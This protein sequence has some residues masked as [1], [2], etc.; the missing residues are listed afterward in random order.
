MAD[1]KSVCSTT[2]SSGPKSRKCRN[3][4]CAN[5]RPYLNRFDHHDLCVHCLGENHDCEHCVDC[6][7]LSARNLQFRKDA[8]QYKREFGKWPPKI[9]SRAM[10]KRKE[11]S[12]REPSATVTASSGDGAK[13][14]SLAEYKARSFKA[15]VVPSIS[16]A[17]SARKRPDQDPPQ[18]ALASK[19]RKLSPPEEEPLVDRKSVV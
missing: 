13:K 4:R 14:I 19:A 6:L 17:L 16:G 1:S 7:N 2:S 8:M 15:P 12:L 10:E 18:Q 3:P 5:P 9:H 11:P